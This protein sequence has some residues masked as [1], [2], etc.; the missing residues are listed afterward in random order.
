MIAIIPIFEEL[1]QKNK[2]YLQMG[3]A[4]GTGVGIGALGHKYGRSDESKIKDAAKV[5]EKSIK[6][7]TDEMPENTLNAV[8][9]FGN[10]MN[11]AKDAYN[12]TQQ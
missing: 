6:K 5:V 11:K 12:S 3:G 1:S 4:L 9:G 8:K 7:T 2:S 10:F